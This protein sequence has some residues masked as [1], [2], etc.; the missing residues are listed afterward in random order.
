MF[1][2]N[3]SKFHGIIQGKSLILNNHLMNMKN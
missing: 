3:L 2:M 1:L